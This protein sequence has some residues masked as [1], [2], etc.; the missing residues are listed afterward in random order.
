MKKRLLFILFLSVFTFCF[1]GQAKADLAPSIFI[2]ELKINE[3]KNNEITGEISISNNEDYYMNDLNYEISLFSGVEFEKLKLV[4]VNASEE[5]FFVAPGKTITKVFTYIYPKN[6]ASGD[7]TIM[8]QII[9][10]RG[11]QLGWKDQKVS[12]NGAGKFLDILGDASKVLVN[13]QEATPLEGINA[14]PKGKV[15]VSLKVKNSGDAVTI[16]PQIKIFQRQINMP[17]VKDYQDFP[18]TFTKGETKDISLTMPQFDKPESYL[19]EV[20]FYKD[21]EQ[22]SAV[23]YFR[24]VVKGEGGKILYIKANKD[25]FKKGEDIEMAVEL[26]GPADGNDI[27]YGKLEISVFNKDGSLMAKKSEDV[28]LNSNLFSTK[29]A[30]RAKNDLTSPII[31]VKL[32]KGSNILDQRKINLPEFSQQAKELGVKIADKKLADEKMAKIFFTYLLPLVVLMILVTVLLVLRFK[33]K[34]K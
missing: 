33:F 34:K 15:V 10:G 30:L 1:F 7:Y 27:G 28:P 9:T 5:M 18:I 11:T 4:D 29:I 2:T 19:A 26:I 21:G 14:L 25:Y 31:D 3:I 32:L 23:Q 13:G 12:L 8:A 20:K 17:V 22:I 16:T 24:W 6:I